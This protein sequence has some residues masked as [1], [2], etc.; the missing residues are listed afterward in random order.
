L[1]RTVADIAAAR[2]EKMGARLVATPAPEPLRV[3]GLEGR[4]GQ[5]FLN[6]AD[7]AV[8]FSP[9]GGEVRLSARRAAGNEVEIRVEDDGPGM[10]EENLERIF[11]RF[12]S[13][14]PESEGFG[15]HSGLGLSI[16]RQIVEAHGGRIW[17]ENRRAPGEGADAPPRGA[18]FT[19]LLPADG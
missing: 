3:R 16:S 4:L 18:R 2:A 15:D 17:A 6:L 1:L 19:V 5:V 9:P 12:Y 11:E 10:P 7:N 8:S 13:A 14:R